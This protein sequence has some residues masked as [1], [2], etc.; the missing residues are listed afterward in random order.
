MATS[1]ILSIGLSGTIASERALATASHNIANA[2]TEGFSRQR[3]EVD[4]RPPQLSGV[5]SLGT[6]VQISNVKRMHDEFILSELR[7]NASLASSLQTSYDFT[8]QIDNML[9]D[10]NAGLAPTLHSF[11]ASINSVANDPS[12]QSAREVMIGEARALAERFAYLDSRF[13]SLRKG[14]NE[15]LKSEIKEVNQLAEAIADINWKIVLAREVT[16]GDPNDLLDQRDRLLHQLSQKVVVRTNEQEDGSLNVFIGN[17]Q[18]LVLGKRHATLDLQANQHD[19]SLLEVVYQ[20]SGQADAVITKFMKGGSIGGLLDFRDHMLDPAQNELGRIAIGITKTFND[21]HHKGMTL[22]N[23]LG[24][25]FFNAIDSN[26]PL[27]LPSAK[28]TGDYELRTT[29]VDT[30]KLTTSDYFLNYNAGVYSLV[31][32]QDEKLIGT[33]TTLPHYIESEGFM[34]ELERGSKI[35]NGDSFMIRP[36]R[37]AARGFDVAITRA[38]DIAAAAPVRV[39]SSVNNL[40][41]AKAE[42]EGVSSV[43]TP[44]FTLEEGKLTP[45]I[46]IR[47]VDETHIELLNADG[48]VILAKQL[49]EQDKDIPA[50]PGLD[51]EKGSPETEDVES[52]HEERLQ[53]SHSLADDDEEKDE[54]IE[55]L[56][57]LID[58]DP[59][60]G[61]R[62]FPTPSGFD[63]GYNVLINGRGKKGDTF[64]I[65]FNKDAIGNNVNMLELG[66]LQNKPT[67]ENGTSNY[68]EVYSQ[69]VSRVGSKTHELD[70][71]R[72]AQSILYEQ[73]KAQRESVSGVNM[74]EEAANLVRYQQ[75]YQ[76]NAQ[77][78]GAANEM[79]DTLIGVL[80][81]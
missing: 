71:N 15:T 48:D 7:S 8:S 23:K 45:S 72:E 40:G 21:H 59:E 78:I 12:S 66:E 50:T 39:R 69:L 56:E 4:Q 17:G 77:V 36:T 74:D 24:G 80:R 81:R 33:F 54:Q 51:G 20:T 61:I 64:I 6:G 22:E 47:F 3:V 75:A 5:G 49:S 14:T 53:G 63:P 60:K 37:A 18:T 19:P 76:A 2:N 79:F 58:Y 35:E 27:S 13:E 70:V 10:P 1:D 62:L 41:N 38:N 65:E 55:T 67:L 32:K 16:Q 11:F 31:R 29:I 43:D 42:L 73:T 52:L 9:A 46:T 26:A 30:D 44:S 25:D 57:N 28:N 68:N 34:I